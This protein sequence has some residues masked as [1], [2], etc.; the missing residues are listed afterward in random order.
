M[1]KEMTRVDLAEL[2]GYTERQLRNIDNE[3]P[4]E[5]KLFVKGAGGKY[6]PNIFVQR[7]VEYREARAQQSGSDLDALKA[8]HEE[9]KIERSKVELSKIRGD[10]VDAKETAAAW[11]NAGVRVRQRM[12]EI[13]LH[14]APRLVGSESEEDIADI[15]TGEIRAALTQLSQETPTTEDG[16]N[17]DGE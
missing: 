13:P 11:V 2:V 3:L 12:M 14:I 9:V 1:I 4:D 10:L 7:W 16:E 6:L 5:Q 15:L 8:I 17:D